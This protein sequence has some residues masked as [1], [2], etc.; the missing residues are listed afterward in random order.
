MKYLVYIIFSAS[1]DRF[2]VGYTESEM[3]V[4]LKKHNANHKGFTGGKADWVIK[5]IE[6]FKTKPGAMKREK[7]LKHGRA[8]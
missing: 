2:Y 3:K 4:R 1:L 6:E 5:Y 7:E 8:G